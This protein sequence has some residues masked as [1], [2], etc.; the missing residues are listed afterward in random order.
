MISPKGAGA[1]PNGDSARID[2]I[3]AGR[4]DNL[5]SSLADHETQA[6]QSVSDARRCEHCGGTFEPRNG[7]GGKPQRFC[8]AECRFA[9]HANG[10]RAQRS[11][12]C[13]EETNREAV[14]APTQEE[15]AP[16]DDGEDF[17]WT[18]T[19]SVVIPEQQAV[20]VYFDSSDDLVIRQ[21]RTWD[22]EE[23]S[24]VIIAKHNVDTLLDRLC[25]IC[26]IPA[27]GGPER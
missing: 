20:A 8:N 27:S 4:P 2:D 9:F 5:Q 18:D 12:T 3:G 22:R 19:K 25:D 13:S 6:A 11:P 1:A 10:Q 7:S 17:C 16:T 14:I 23:D 24:I 21:E 26:G 15:S